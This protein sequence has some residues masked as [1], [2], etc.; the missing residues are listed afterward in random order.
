MGAGREGVLSQ[1]VHCH[2]LTNE[3][4]NC[5]FTVFHPSGH[6]MILILVISHI[7]SNSGG[8]NVKPFHLFCLIIVSCAEKLDQWDIVKQ[9]M[10]FRVFEVIMNPKIDKD[11]FIVMGH[12]SKTEIFH[13]CESI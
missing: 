11:I 3:E 1:F 9:Q 6:L 8:I 7:V 13:A 12:G 10:K 2:H 5:I 4:C